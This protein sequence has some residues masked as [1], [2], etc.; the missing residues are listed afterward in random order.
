MPNQ[1]VPLLI[2]T[3]SEKVKMTPLAW[4]ITPESIVIIF[5]QGPKMVFE[6]KDWEEVENPKL[7][8]PEAITKKVG[9][10]F[11]PPNGSKP[12]I[13]RPIVKKISPKANRK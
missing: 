2:L 3:L 6:R 12:V 9:A 13:R 7:Q 5:E 8:P 11:V 1:P 4:K 10:R